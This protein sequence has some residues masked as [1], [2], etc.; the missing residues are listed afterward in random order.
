MP[1]T[2]DGP[3]HL[4]ERSGGSHNLRMAINCLT[5]ISTDGAGKVGVN[6]A[7]QPV[8]TEGVSSDTSRAEILSRQHTSCSQDSDECVEGRQLWI[9]V[10]C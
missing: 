10:A 5:C 1:P 7:C 9:L 2:D 8:V 4:G 6:R 3:G